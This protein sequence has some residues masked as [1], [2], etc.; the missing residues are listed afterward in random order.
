[1][2]QGTWNA[3]PI[4]H[5]QLKRNTLP[6][7]KKREAFGLGPKLL[8]FER[9]RSVFSSSTDVG[10]M[11]IFITIYQAPLSNAAQETELLVV[12]Q[13]TYLVAYRIVV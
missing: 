11:R 10:C 9:I 5:S 3:I 8:S 12:V 13:S 7:I 4:L 1:M 6:N 2:I